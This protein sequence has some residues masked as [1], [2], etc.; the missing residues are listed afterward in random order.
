MRIGT[1]LR[2]NLLYYRRTNLAV[3]CGVAAAVA[4]LSGAMLVGDSVRGSLRDLVVRRLGATD[5]VVSA[6]R[7]FREPLADTLKTNP[8][9]ATHTPA[10]CPIIHLQGVVIH[11][12]SGRRAQK[13]S[14]YGIDERFWRFHGFEQP[15]G[16]RDRE[17]LPGEP[18]A[19]ELGARPGETLLLRLEKQDE[20]PKE[21]LYGRREDAGRT[22]RLE[23]REPLPD[24]ELGDFSLQPGQAEVFTLFVPLD[25]LQRDLAQPGRANT[26]LLSTTAPDAA[27]V[28][29]ALDASLLTEDAGLRFKGMPYA[30]AS[31]LESDRILLSEP[32]ADAALTAAAAAGLM[33]S[34]VY[35]YLA[36]SIR[37]GSLEIPYSVITAASLGQGALADIRF[38]RG[39]PS[40]DPQGAAD[41]IWLN[42]WAW[43]ELEPDIGSPIEVSYFTWRDEGRLETET[44]EFH[45][46]GVVAI[47]GDIGPALAP[48]FP[49]ITEA[50]SIHDWDPPFP[51]DMRRIRSED[52]RY[53]DQYRATPKA[54]I[55]LARGQEL[56]GTRFGKLTTIVLKPAPGADPG[57]LQSFPGKL[58]EALHPEQAGFSITPV[59]S[60][61]LAASQG[62]T[63]FGEYFVYFS[64]FLIASA[65]LLAAL[66]FRLGI[67][68]RLREIGTLQA[69]GF[70]PARI[71]NIFLAEAGVICGAGCLLGVPAAT[72]YAALLMF[73]LRTWWVDAVGTRQ[74]ELHVS[75]TSLLAGASIGLVAAFVSTVW[76]LRGVAYNSPRA[77]LAGAVYG[78]ATH[79]RRR[80]RSLI[81]GAVTATAAL[82]L[83]ALSGAGMLSDVGGFFGAGFLLLVSALAA[84]AAYFRR[85]RVPPV[86]PAT[87]LSFLKLGSRNASYRPG[88]SVLCVALIAAATFTIVSVEA[89][90]QDP[91]RISLDPGSGTGGFPLIAESVLPIVDDLNSTQGSASLGLDLESLS[92]EGVRF[93]PFRLKPGDDTSCLNLYVPQEP[94]VLGVPESLT[95]SG[96]FAFA[97]SLAADAARRNNPWLLLDSPQ[98]DGAI[99][100]IGDANTIRY[101]LHRRLGDDVIVDGGGQP[102][103]LRLVAALRDSI[104][105]SE[106]LISESNF[107]RSFPGQQGFRYFLIDVPPAHA[108]GATQPLEEQLADYGFD[109]HSAPERLA[110]FHKVENTYLSTFQSLGALGLILGT[111]GLGTV[112]LRNVLER[113]KELALLRT[114]GFR[115]GTLALV[116]V[117]ENM[118]LLVLGLFG[119][120][121]SALIAVSP[122]LLSRVTAFPVGGLALLLGAVFATGLAASVAAVVAALRSP[123]LASLRSE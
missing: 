56:W 66:F 49:G 69:Q 36:I 96:R 88:R 50:D 21:S 24:S 75:W 67:E 59:R 6:D 84:S 38:L 30:N 61:G 27:P 73:G 92:P 63:D 111:A 90:R 79:S 29:A 123:L 91:G 40:N 120:T 68:Q 46:A 17:A 65:T 45:F 51:M 47:G 39:A 31:A 19:R 43:R 60:V 28:R 121:V 52:E 62:S 110:S 82:V 15:S 89:F 16:P 105:Q 98:P 22:I 99:P 80:R 108:A 85:E 10:T 35:T 83:L 94:R 9:L 12:G 74:L 57:A 81:L 87:R 18:L 32:V 44:R 113:R 93:Y 13:V 4:V 118:V 37:A 76:T 48:D 11:E 64:F 7:F 116:V 103:K 78:A 71:R 114:V 102:L 58:M 70:A 41:R 34:P 115:G 2:R 54:F 42:E 97:E 104:F 3:V 33:A 23:C 53:W 100:A 109:V 95:K 122:A 86:L 112:L 117:A 101:I 14:V 5:Y 77:L 1:L 26:I 55:P 106:L 107:R 119:G 25:R 72:G 20:I 8:A